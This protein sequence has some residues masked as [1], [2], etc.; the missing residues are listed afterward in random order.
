MRSFLL[1]FIFL[2]LAMSAT[3][4]EPIFVIPLKGEVSQAQFFFLRRALK[5]AERE[6][7]SAVIL[8]M[9]TYGGELNAA[10]KM[11]DAL[12][13]T[14]APTITYINSNAGSAGALVA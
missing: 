11:L 10:V 14:S 9:D 4:A 3:R 7:A 8:D 2:A 12:F 13:K 1:T 6:K 5:Q